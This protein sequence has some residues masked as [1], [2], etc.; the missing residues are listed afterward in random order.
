MVFR[1]FRS[2]KTT[3]EV[4][5]FEG[6]HRDRDRYRIG[7]GNRAGWVE[8]NRIMSRGVNGIDGGLVERCR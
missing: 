7:C 6:D 1:R 5:Y 8:V 3:S 4:M 2:F